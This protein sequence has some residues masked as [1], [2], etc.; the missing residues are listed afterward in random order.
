VAQVAQAEGRRRPT[1][2]RVARLQLRRAGPPPLPALLEPEALHLLPLER[3][4]QHLLP[5]E[6][7]ARHLLLLA[8]E[9]LHPL[10]VAVPE[11]TL[12]RLALPLILAHPHA[13]RP[14]PKSPKAAMAAR[15]EPV[16]TVLAP[17]YMTPSAAWTCIM[18]S[19]ETGASR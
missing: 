10:L 11:G 7:G 18:G 2:Q 5:L 4:A 1:R 6:P 14:D 8:P 3:G 13:H 19:T 16:R 9:A 17:T 12:P 15:S